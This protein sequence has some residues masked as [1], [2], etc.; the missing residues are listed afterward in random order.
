M[1]KKKTTQGWGGRRKG[2]G[3]KPLIIGRPKKILLN[4]RVTGEELAAI[5]AEA[6]RRGLSVAAM[7]RAA[8]CRPVKDEVEGDDGGEGV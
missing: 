1:E 2:S 7:I 4:F 5:Q 6:R 8:F 3:R